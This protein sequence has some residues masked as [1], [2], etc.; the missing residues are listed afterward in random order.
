MSDHA[1]DDLVREATRLRYSRRGILKRASALGL[2]APAA[3]AVLA[4]TGAPAAAS[5]R[6]GPTTLTWFASRDTSGFIPTLVDA[7]NAQD[8]NLQISY[9]EQGA[10]TVD[11][12]DKFSTVAGAQDASVD[13]ISVDV[14]YVPEFAAAGWTMPLDE[15]FPAGER[16]GFYPSAIEGATYDAG[17][18]AQLYAVPWYNNGPGLF[19][20]KDLLDGAG[21]APPKT[22]DELQ[23]IATQLQ[24]PEIAGFVFQASQTEGGAISFLETLWGHGGDVLDAEGNVVLGDGPGVEA[25]QRLIDYVYTAKISP[26]STLAL[27]TAADAQNVFVEGKAVF[28]RMWMTATSA[29]DA[30]TAAVKGLWD[31]TTLPSKDGTQPGPGCLG[32]W[33]LGISAFSEQAE[34]AA[35]AIRFFTAAEQQTQLY[36]G[37]GSLPARPAVFDAP[38]VTAKYPYVA[39]LRTTFESLK[40][41]PVTPYYNTISA[42]V[43]R[44]N[45]GA[46]MARDKEPQQAIDDMVSGIEG[47]LAG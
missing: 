19:Y 18:G 45:F 32:T 1:I 22:Y 8:P 34:P 30:D 46:A 36:L 2:A 11:L 7:F 35:E 9:Q 41:R 44:P 37:N 47:V 17:E 13:L 10:T 24:T 27:A 3:A 28:L 33:N 4:R 26:E 21:L 14:P 20:R 16:E 42:D 39:Q 23:R 12:R 43:L 29:M 15:F 25:L 38:E 5:R 31:V 6:Q 40:P